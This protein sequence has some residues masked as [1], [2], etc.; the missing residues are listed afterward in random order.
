MGQQQWTIL[1]TGQSSAADNM[2]LDAKLLESLDEH[3]LPILHFY[4]WKGDSAT[5]GYFVNPADFLDLSQVKKKKLD[6]ARRPTG[7]GI[8]FHTWDLAFSIL[9]PA[10]HPY[11][12]ENTLDNY[13]F[14]NQGVLEAVTQLLNG[15]QSL[16]LIYE[17]AFALD[18]SCKRFC[19]AQPTKYD[20]V[21]EGKKIAGAAQRKTK[22][23]FLHQGTIALKFPDEAYLEQLLLPNTKVK[24][25]ILA[26]SFSLLAEHE[27]IEEGR[28][29]IKQALIEAFTQEFS[30]VTKNSH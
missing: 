11:F 4:D 20:V 24:D 14:V 15:R 19:M 26:H 27:K 25:A 3:A 13:A 1:D 28:K 7:G 10:K 29:E 23:G 30:H 12:S 5:Y 18:P 22:K 21:V 2:A 17:D 6:L 16:E 9:V 8:V